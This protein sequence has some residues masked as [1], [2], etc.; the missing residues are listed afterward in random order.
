MKPSLTAPALNPPST[1]K[2]PVNMLILPPQNFVVSLTSSR[3][4]LL[5]EIER[6]RDHALLRRDRRCIHPI[7]ACRPHQVHHLRQRIDVRIRHKPVRPGIRML[8]VIP[9]QRRTRIAD[10]SRHRYPARRSIRCSQSIARSSV[11]ASPIETTC[12]SALEPTSKTARPTIHLADQRLLK[13]PAALSLEHHMMP[14]IRPPIRWPR[15]LGVGHIRSHHLRP[16]PLR[17][18]RRRTHIHHSKEIHGYFPSMWIAPITLE[19]SCFKSCTP[20]LNRS[21]AFA[22]CKPSRSIDTLFPS[23][24]ATRPSTSCAATCTPSRPAAPVLSFNCRANSNSKSKLCV[25]YPGVSTLAILLA[26]NCI[27]RLVKSRYC[28]SASLIAVVVCMH[29][30]HAMTHAVLQPKKSALR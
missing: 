18:Q 30:L 23:G 16:H 15:R 8:R 11:R 26:V 22:S 4:A 12:K 29:H 20:S 19:N 5:Q 7:R 21:C 27:C 24:R 13:T 3:I 2:P 1:P 10:H 6:C 14:L 28:P 9:H 25:L 17:L